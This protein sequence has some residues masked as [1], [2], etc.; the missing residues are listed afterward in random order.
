MTD[1]ESLVPSDG[2]VDDGERI[3]QAGLTDTEVLAR[4]IVESP[5]RCTLPEVLHSGSS[6]RTG[7][8]NLQQQ[9]DVSSP[10]AQQESKALQ[11][12]PAFDSTK[13]RL[14]YS[15]ALTAPTS[16]ISDPINSV[17]FSEK[18]ASSLERSIKPPPDFQDPYLI[19][20]LSPLEKQR[21][22]KVWY[23]CQGIERDPELREHLSQLV[24]LVRDTTHYEIAILG[25]VDLDIFKRTITINCPMAV[26][27]RQE[28]T[29]SH[30]ILQK[31]GTVFS[32]P[33][34]DQDWRTMKSPP[35]EN[36]GLK[37]YAGTQLSYKIPGTE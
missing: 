14:F 9:E 25:F 8:T 36:L 28:S 24:S 30:T 35:V 3:N 12:L 13:F 18:T 34:M 16:T 21:L 4:Y 32:L 17:T 15:G 5:R 26:V 7:R 37:A 27:Q 6:P 19:P 33:E 29:C 31:P 20:M 2:L 10:L 22:T 11:P 1:F 23:I